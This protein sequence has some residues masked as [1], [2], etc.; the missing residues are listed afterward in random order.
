[1][2]PQS[3]STSHGPAASARRRNSWRL[4]LLATIAL[5]VFMLCASVLV[6]ASHSASPG[7]DAA[8][9]FTVQGERTMQGAKLAMRGSGWPASSTVTLSG[10]PPPGGPTPLDLGTARVNSDGEFRATKLSDCT[11][12]TAPDP[13]ARVTITAM[14]GDIKVEQLVDAALWHCMSGVAARN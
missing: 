2:S 4:A 7:D 9:A 13:K 10:S 3:D 6:A 14:H 5:G 11:T 12:A 8:P 1:M